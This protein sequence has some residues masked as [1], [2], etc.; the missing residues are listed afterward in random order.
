MTY[1]E[2]L[3]F[4][5]DRVDFERKPAEPNDLKL[6]RMRLLL[7]R[8]EDPHERLRIIHVAGSKGK[9]S[10]SAMLA[11]CLQ[12]AGYRTGLFTSPH[13]TDVTERIQ[14]DRMPIGPEQLAE[15]MSELRP[16]VEELQRAGSPPT[17]FE[18]GTALGFLHFAM[19]G[20]DVAVIEVGLGGRF[21]STNVCSPALS[22][23]TSISHDHTAILGNRLSEIAREKAG[24]VKPGVP[25]VSGVTD[26]EA[27]AVVREICAARSAALAELDREFRYRHSPAQVTRTG[28]E[29]LPRV[30]VETRRQ[31]WNDLEMDLLG[32]HQAHNAAVAVAAIEVLRN[33]GLAVANSAVTA[34][35]RSVNWPARMEVLPGPPLTVLDC[36]H[37]VASA[38]ALADTLRASF[39]PGR[40]VL[41]FAVASDKDVTGM[42]RVLAP[43]FDAFVLTRFQSNPRSAP[44]DQLAAHLRQVRPDAEITVRDNSA[45][46]LATATNRAD[47]ELIVIAGSVYLAGELRPLLTPDS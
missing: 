43:L 42:F 11:A 1:E 12:R 9:G 33:A 45:S 22:V 36:A 24:I 31:R 25:V 15:R 39:P 16:A 38:Q 2:A 32:D 7:N 28:I 21:D 5:C 30:S 8:I 3:A 29:R 41:V 37:N 23:I 40:R 46:A 18:V 4:W 47:S 35:L 14:I 27:A 34:G 10:T 19:A 6:D 13:L 20:V 17:F 26:A 44:P